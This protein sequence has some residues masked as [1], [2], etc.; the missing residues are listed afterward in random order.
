MPLVDLSRKPVAPL[1]RNESRTTLS[2]PPPPPRLR[3]G[4]ILPKGSGFRYIFSLLA[5]A[6]EVLGWNPDPKQREALNARRARRVLNWARQCG[7][8]E[9]AAIIAIHVACTRPGSLTVIIGAVG[10]HINTFFDRIDQFL[11]QAAA[12]AAEKKG[13]PEAIDDHTA[14]LGGPVTKTSA[15]NHRVIRRFPNRSRILGLTTRKAVRSHTARLIILDEAGDI[16]GPVWEGVL[17]TLA[18]TDGDILVIG[19]P[20]GAKGWYYDLWKNPHNTQGPRGWFKSQYPASENPRISPE[21]LAEMRLT[22]GEAWMRQEFG[23]EFLHDGR[24]LLHPDDVDALF[25][26]KE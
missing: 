9:T 14:W 7:K 18:T 3:K 2:A 24:T 12:L 13:N 15:A 19:T 5:F 22:K 10:D 17:P 23:C 26:Y 16:E 4:E 8:T 21:Y 6:L 25:D 20:K 11:D 1:N